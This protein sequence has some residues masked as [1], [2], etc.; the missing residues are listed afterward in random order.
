MPSWQTDVMPL[1]A[2]NCVRCHMYPHR[3]DGQTALR[4]DS[5]EDTL[6]PGGRVAKGAKLTIGGIYRRTNEINLTPDQRPM[7]PDRP[8]TEYELEVLN[9]WA[10]RSNGES[11][12]RGAGREDNHAPTI[13]VAESY[14]D[15][16]TI[17]FTYDVQDRDGDL[18]VATFGVRLMSRDGDRLRSD[19]LILGNAIAGI[20]ESELY[21]DEL[22]KGFPGGDFP[23]F[24]QVDDGADV[25]PEGEK[26]F[27][28]VDLGMISL[29]AGPPMTTP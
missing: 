9:L 25:D 14:R 7:P 13:V 21:I 16:E 24:A 3:G 28:Q 8:L 1:F 23:Y 22:P 12:V 20:G 2:A 17:R 10:E 18:V 11:A 6:H 27:V 19:D 5:F 15:S 29:P 26:D 4:L